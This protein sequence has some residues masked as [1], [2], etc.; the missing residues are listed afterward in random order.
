[1]TIIDFNKN[2]DGLVPAIIQDSNTKNVLMLGYMNEEAFNTTKKTQKVT[3]YS[4]SKK[5]LWMKGE[6]SGNVL[7]VVDINCGLESI[8]V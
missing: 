6:E 5:R 7:N 1:M 4:R 3:F 2:N 8:I